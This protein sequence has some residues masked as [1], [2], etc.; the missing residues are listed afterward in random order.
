[1]T[2]VCKLFDCSVC[3]AYGKICI[4]G[5]DADIESITICPVCGSDLTLE[6]FD[7]DESDDE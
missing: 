3:E 2:Q 6:V 5:P 1:M 4:K 7:G